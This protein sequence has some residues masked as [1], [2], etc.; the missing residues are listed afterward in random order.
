MNEKP[1]I[2]AQEKDNNHTYKHRTSKQTAADAERE[3]RQLFL[4]GAIAFVM[5]EGYMIIFIIVHEGHDSFYF[6]CT[7][8][9][10][11]FCH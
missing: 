6:L 8:T 4:G 10:Y 11:S 7:G 1:H 3:S 2:Q 9:R 5:N